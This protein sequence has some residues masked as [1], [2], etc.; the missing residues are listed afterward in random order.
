M[1]T[2]SRWFRAVVTIPR[3]LSD[4]STSAEAREIEILRD[5]DGF[6]VASAIRGMS[7][8]RW[9]QGGFTI[10]FQIPRIQLG[11]GPFGRDRL[12]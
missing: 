8:A 7:S 11:I 5:E 9:K 4:G 10:E 3:V 12:A 6:Q 2:E 1:R